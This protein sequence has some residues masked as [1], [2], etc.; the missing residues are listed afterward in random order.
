ML[1]LFPE[2]KDEKDI[3]SVFIYYELNDA[4]DI[5]YIYIYIDKKV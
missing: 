2:T 1:R 5:L 3:E 4:T